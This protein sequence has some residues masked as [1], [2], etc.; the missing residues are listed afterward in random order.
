MNNASSPRLR[1]HFAFLACAGLLCVASVH[2]RRVSLTDHEMSEVNARGV[3]F[4]ENIV[5]YDGLDFSTVAINADVTLNANFKNISLG[6]YLRQGSNS[7]TDINISALQFGRSAA[8]A[9]GVK[10][11][12]A[13][14]LV[15]ISNPYIQFVYD[16]KSGPK[17]MVGV[18][19]GFDSI[20]GDIGFAANVISGSMYVDGKDLTGVNSVL[21][22]TGTRWSGS[23]KPCTTSSCPTYLNLSDIGAI[24]AGDA[25]GPS[26]DFWI[27]VLMKPVNFPPPTKW[28]DG[29][30]QTAPQTAEAGYWLNWRDKLVALSASLPP[31]KALGK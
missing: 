22:A 27:S 19:L 10:F 11:E 6:T 18:R 12:E 15:E 24:R 23:N 25:N 3:L 7:N 26:R 2:A 29:P 17:Q 8:T 21:D 5:N 4:L 9:N 31:N 28:P 16:N 30:Q 13:N 20:K 14:R 1:R